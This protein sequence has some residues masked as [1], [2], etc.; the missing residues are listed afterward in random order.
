M[1]QKKLLLSFISILM[2]ANV[3]CAAKPKVIKFAISDTTYK[4]FAKDHSKEELLGFD[5]ELAKKLCEGMNTKCVF[6]KGCMGN[7]VPALRSGK[8]DAWISSVSI[9]AERSKAVTFSDIYFSSTAKLLATKDSTFNAAPVEI[10]GRTIG[11]EADTSYI[12]YVKAI[13]GN[14][15]KI[16]I[17]ADGQKVLN[18]LKTGKVEAIIDDEIVL[19]H[20]RAE[21][22]DSKNYRLIGLPAKHL[23]LI[24][25][26]YAIAVA[27]DNLKLVTAINKALAELKSD[28]TY[29]AIIKKHFEG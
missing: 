23:D 3:A 5:I 10:E 20:W 8:Y 2:L 29:N 15:I 25:Q 22:K 4:P 19:K 17:F 7:M 11:V 24:I 26:Q 13:Y 12:P 21:Q 1:N 9:T 18:A 14:N 16:N 27:K 6:A 28:G